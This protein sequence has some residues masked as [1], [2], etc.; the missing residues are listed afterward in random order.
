MAN[1]YL[2]NQLLTSNTSEA[3][4]KAGAMNQYI[5]EL[6]TL[7]HELGYDNE[8]QWSTYGA[9]GYYG[10]P[11]V[12]AVGTYGYKNGIATNGMS[13]SSQLL[14]HMLQAAGQNASQGQSPAPAQPQRPA[15]PTPPPAQ[16]PAAPAPAQLQIQDQGDTILVSDGRQQVKLFKRDNGYAYWGSVTIDQA[17]ARNAATIKS[18]GITDSALKVMKSVSE[19]EGKLDSINSY[20]R[21]YFSFGI[22]QWTIGVDSTGELPALL[23]KYKANFG[24]AFAQYFGTYGLDV[25][26]DTN[27]TYGYL[28]LNGNKIDQAA[29]KEQFRKPEWAFRFWAAGQDAQ[30]QAVEVEHALSRLKAFYWNPKF[31]INGF[32]LSEIITSE[33]GVALILDN[34]VNRPSYVQPSI[35]K[36]MQQTGLNNPTLWG[37]A[38]E[39]KVIDAYLQIRT[40]FTTGSYNPMTKAQ[41]RA[42]VTQ[43]YLANGTI[44]AERNSFQYTQQMIS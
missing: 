37:T 17:I 13:V 8:L 7:M 42:A 21:A 19:N 15:A 5:G 9:D 11:V 22:F 41:E 23:K 30:L 2:L 26:P 39:K 38:E 10:Q 33:Y 29:E 20:D 18:L 4:L 24:S 36:A 1:T 16:K 32:T 34:H 44:S 43:K 6:Q 25:S 35:E 12:N 28:S 3:Q 31:A 14:S 27:D 40:T